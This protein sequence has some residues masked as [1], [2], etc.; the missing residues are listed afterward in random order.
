LIGEGFRKL[1][2]AAHPGG[3]ILA[4]PCINGRR[5]DSAFNPMSRRNSVSRRMQHKLIVTHALFVT[6]LSFGALLRVG[7]DSSNSDVTVFGSIFVFLLIIAFS[8]LNQFVIQRLNEYNAKWP[9]LNYCGPAAALMIL[10]LILHIPVDGLNL[11]FFTTLILVA[12]L[13]LY[14]AVGKDVMTRTR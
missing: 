3:Y 7:L 6:I 2:T 5:I 14:S 10:V 13:I 11:F 9:I 12:N 1:S 4:M 8:F